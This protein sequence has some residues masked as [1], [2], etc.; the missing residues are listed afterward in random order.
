MYLTYPWKI[1]RK[2]SK[3]CWNWRASYKGRVIIWFCQC[4][5]HL[6]VWREDIIKVTWVWTVQ[7]NTT[8]WENGRKNLLR[9]VTKKMMKCNF[10]VFVFVLGGQVSVSQFFILVLVVL[11]SF[12]I[13]VLVSVYVS[14][15]D[16]HTGFDLCVGG[17][18]LCNTLPG[19]VGV[20]VEVDDNF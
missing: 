14:V 4:N 8:C 19:Y 9:V 1:A 17:T 18:M 15:L 3:K 11:F 10:K 7:L 16:L 13:L 20:L 2:N 12:L 6:H 5:S